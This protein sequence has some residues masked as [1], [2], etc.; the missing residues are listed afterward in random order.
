LALSWILS[1]LGVFLRDIGQ[2]LGVA[3]NL[4][5]FMSAVFYPVSSLP[6]QW[7]LLIQ[8]NPLVLVIE[9]TRRVAVAGL[10]PNPLYVAIGIPITILACE[11]SYR[12]FQKA[13]R[14]FADVL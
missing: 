13:R 4:L 1:A 2:I 7:Q 3:V 14:G 9:Q 10:P 12:F 6:S 8:F 11:S 5:M